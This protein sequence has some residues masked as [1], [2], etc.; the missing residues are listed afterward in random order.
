V[1]SSTNSTIDAKPDFAVMT[2]QAEAQKKDL[3]FV[4]LSL[5]E[6]EGRES[7]LKL[8]QTQLEN[9]KWFIKQRDC[10]EAGLGQCPDRG[11]FMKNQGKRT[12][13]DT[14]VGKYCNGS[15][16]E[17]KVLRS[18]RLDLFV[19]Y[20]ILFNVKQFQD[21]QRK[22]L[23]DVFADEINQYFSVQVP[24]SVIPPWA[25]DRIK[26]NVEG[27]A[28]AAQLF[29]KGIPISSFGTTSLLTCSELDNNLT[30]TPLPSTPSQHTESPASKR[31]EVHN[32]LPS[33]NHFSHLRLGISYPRRA[34]MVFCPRIRQTQMRRSIISPVATSHC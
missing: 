18:L 14:I 19:R 3:L 11:A 15:A 8:E 13:F 20:C 1:D 30:D 17:K 6:I 12:S 32:D 4:N 33:S 16:G 24:T 29:R 23:Q 10:L 25:I 21:I 26:S 31:I 27:N 7:K 2:N 28:E 5:D 9:S 34:D 22:G